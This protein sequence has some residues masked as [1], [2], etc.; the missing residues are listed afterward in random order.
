MFFSQPKG[1]GWQKGRQGRG[2]MD[3]MGRIHADR[4]VERLR[5]EVK[6]ITFKDVRGEES[7]QSGRRPENLGSLKCRGS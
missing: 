3:V 5:A 2:E 4:L 1:V 7:M 6:S